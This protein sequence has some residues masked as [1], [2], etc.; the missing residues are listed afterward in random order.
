MPDF[1]TEIRLII[2]LGNPGADYA[3]TRHNAGFWLINALA[4]HCSQKFHLDKRFN[5][6]AARINLHNTDILLIKPLTFMNK[7]GQTVGAVTRYYR[8][9]TSQVLVLHDELDLKPGDNR[10]KFGGG[11]GGHNGIRDI[12]IHLHEHDFYRLRIGIGH[13]GIRNQVVNYVL[14]QPSMEDL[15][16]IKTANTKTL[17]IMPLILAG[18]IDKAM[19]IL[20]T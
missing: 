9:Q 1:D 11:H 16:A 18:Q 5:A 15:E 14:H 3:E 20:H 12:I 4:K 13:P 7:S 8:F 17:D 19:Q 2:G 10:L 6:E